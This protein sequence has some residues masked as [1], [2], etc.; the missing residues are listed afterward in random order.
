MHDGADS[1]YRFVVDEDSLDWRGRTDVEVHDLVDTLAEL[2][3]PLADGRQVVLMTHAYIMECWE[4]VAVADIA[5]TADRRVSRDSRVRLAKLLDKCRAIEPQDGDIPQQVRFHDVCKEPSWGVSH[6]L[7]QAAAGR[8]MAVLG[9]P[10]VDGP[11]GWTAFERVADQLQVE[12]H[13][14]T[15]PS[16]VQEFWR[17]VFS[18]EPV[19]PEEFFVLAKRAFTRLLF[20]EDLNFARFR[21]NYAEVLPWVVQLLS[22]LDDRFG[23]ALAEHRGDHNRVMAEFS[24][25]GI[26]ISPE[27]PQTHKNES[28]WNRRLVPYGDTRYRCDWH[29]K[30]LWNLDRVHFSRPLSEYQGRV[31]IGI[32]TDHLPT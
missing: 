5:Y 14:L 10:I 25:L 28:A 27:S 29:G 9:V 23:A 26:D 8:A 18:R 16:Q 11:S 3:E 21:G 17:G 2:L 6:A 4:G 1:D 20:A 19:S 15:D 7:A 32:F 30:R 22:A 24:A 12:L 13:L 31:L